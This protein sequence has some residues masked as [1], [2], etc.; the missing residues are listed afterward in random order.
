MLITEESI[1]C[2]N[3][4]LIFD[5][6]VIR[7]IIENGNY[8]IDNQRYNILDAFNF[9]YNFDYQ[10]FNPYKLGLIRVVNEKTKTGLLKQRFVIDYERVN[11]CYTIS[12]DGVV[13]GLFLAVPCG[14]CLMCKHS[15]SSQLVTRMELESECH[16][17]RPLF[18]TLTY[19]PAWLPLNGVRKNHIQL[20]MKRL[21]NHFKN[22]KIRYCIVSEYG[23][24]DIYTDHRGRLRRGTARP[25]YHLVLYGI[26]YIA[27]SPVSMSRVIN[28]I[29]KAWSSDG[30]TKES[31]PFGQ[32]FVE[33]CDRGAFRYVAKYI[34][35]T[36]EVP[37]G[38]K[39]NFCLTSRRPGLGAPFIDKMALYQFFSQHPT[40]DYQ[41]KAYDGQ[42]V[43]LFPCK[44]LVNKLFPTFSM[45]VPLELRKSFDI[46]VHSLNSLATLGYHVEPLKEYFCS[47]L[48]KFRKLG[49][50]VPN[51]HRHDVKLWSIVEL[52]MAG[53][54]PQNELI[55]S[56][57][58]TCPALRINAAVTHHL[59]LLRSCASIL[60]KYKDIDIDMIFNNMRLRSV[61][62]SSLRLRLQNTE[63]KQD[64]LYNLSLKYDKH[65][66]QSKF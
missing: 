11:K 18:V 44:Y 41:Y 29:I 30:R 53:T 10:R 62:Y 36:N 34:V 37:K 64:K 28:A 3:P 56:S 35:K 1:N 61:L 47:F 54:S 40:H 23:K 26:N 14:H 25:H 13:D 6:S 48:P 65:L 4:Q 45:A 51:V 52:H 20:F 21:R 2:E 32:V 49:Y 50:R 27:N 66:S 43:K 17:S 59:S 33:P 16:N 39:P 58:K 46:M 7:K 8:Y 55:D 63:T 12:K 60:E 22:D 5:R 19:A 38:C 57:S 15:K 24:N 9:S 42:I 31:E